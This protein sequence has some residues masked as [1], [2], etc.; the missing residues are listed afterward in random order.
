MM[1]RESEKKGTLHNVKRNTLISQTWCYGTESLVFINV[2]TADG[3][4]KMNADLY[5]TKVAELHSVDR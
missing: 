5:I 4:V 2:G 1:G 3:S